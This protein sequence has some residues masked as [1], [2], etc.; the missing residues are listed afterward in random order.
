MIDDCCMVISNVKSC[1]YLV[2]NLYKPDKFMVHQ[3]HV[4]WF[5]ILFMLNNYEL[6]FLFFIK[7]YF[8]LFSI[9]EYIYVFIFKYYNIP[10]FMNIYILFVQLFKQFLNCY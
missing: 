1:L 6:L 7:I 10:I 8:I 4:N 2:D 3:L 9:P 5:L